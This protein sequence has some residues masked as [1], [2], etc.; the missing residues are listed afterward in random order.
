MMLK[1]YRMR[2]VLDDDVRLL[3][4]LMSVHMYNRVNVYM[5][6]KQVNGNI[7]Y[8]MDNEVRDPSIQL[9]LF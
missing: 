8:M 1:I 3:F 5:V 9:Y 2:I 7:L 6:N 4:E